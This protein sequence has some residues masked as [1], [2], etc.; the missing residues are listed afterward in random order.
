MVNK[1]NI[2]HKGSVAMHPLATNTLE[3]CSVY[4]LCSLIWI[5]QMCIVVICLVL[6]A[7]RVSWT[8]WTIVGSSG[9]ALTVLCCMVQ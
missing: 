8:K 6:C 9:S 3:A 7:D 4:C 1:S 5:C 2:S